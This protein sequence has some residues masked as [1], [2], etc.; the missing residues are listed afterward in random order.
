MTFLECCYNQLTDLDL[1][2]NVNLT[3]LYCDNTVT[4]IG[5]YEKS[6]NEN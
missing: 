1:S 2:N 5:Y 6:Q 3:Y 4:V